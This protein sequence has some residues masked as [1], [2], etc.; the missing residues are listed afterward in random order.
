M[1]SNLTSL[2]LSFFPS[3]FPSLSISAFVSGTFLRCDRGGGCAVSVYLFRPIFIF[4]YFYF[5]F[6]IFIK[7]ETMIKH[8]EMCVSV[9]L[10]VNLLWFKGDSHTSNK[11]AASGVVEDVNKTVF[12]VFFF[13]PAA[14]AA[15]A[16]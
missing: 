12:L 8:D 15:E 16:R 6:F 1:A 14:A 4:I 5:L 13:L 3:S 11:A 7:G 10:Y 9:H 2:L